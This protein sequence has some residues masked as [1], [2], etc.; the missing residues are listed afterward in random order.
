MSKGLGDIAT[1]FDVDISFDWIDYTPGAVVSQQAEEM[2]IQA[3]TEVLGS[4]SVAPHSLPRE[5]MTFIF[6]RS[7][8]QMSMQQ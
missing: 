3:I 5:V 1:L 8:I 2:A 6:I 4:E 7:N